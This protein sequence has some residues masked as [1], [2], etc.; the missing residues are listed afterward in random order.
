MAGRRL[1]AA[2]AEALESRLLATPDDLE[3][4]V[5]LAAYYGPV[6][7]RRVPHALWLIAHH[8]S[9]DLVALADIFDET[10]D[11]HR[12]ATRLWL[13]AIERDPR[14]SAIRHN[15]YHAFAVAD[16]EL[17]EKVVRDGIALEPTSPEWW[18]QLAHHHVRAATF[19]VD[20]ERPALWRAAIDE[21]ERAIE[22]TAPDE[23]APAA[24][25]E[26]GGCSDPQTSRYSMTIDLAKVVLESG[27]LDRA[28]ALAQQILDDATRLAGTWVHGNGIHWGNIVLGRIAFA[29]EDVDAARAYLAAAAATPGSP[30]LDSFG[31]DQD[32]A[33]AFL[34]RGDRDTVIA[35]I[36][37]VRR[38]FAGPL[39]MLTGAYATTLTVLDGGKK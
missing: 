34:K 7:P 37:A 12:E 2:D 30:Q 33:A 26:L 5:K 9:Y 8:P 21:Y 39:G 20:D 36:E 35:Y 32:L 24:T 22:L 13:A 16:D 28:R 29:R 6:D 31:P 11:A 19:G 25:C 15:A 14:N 4:R 18:R 17:A 10:S 1:S 23:T 38:F 3:S 27:E